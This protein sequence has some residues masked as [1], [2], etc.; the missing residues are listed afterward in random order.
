M[1]TVQEPELND[2]CG[3][4]LHDERATRR[5]ISFSEANPALLSSCPEVIH[6]AL[7]SAF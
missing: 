3:F 4:F 5:L 1:S 6:F 2:W 7:Q